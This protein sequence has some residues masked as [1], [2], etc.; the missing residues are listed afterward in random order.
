MA[1]ELTGDFDVVAEFAVPAA[2]R[3]LA[4][5][6]RSERFL[7]S[8]SIRVDDHARPGPTVDWPVVVGSLDTAGDPTVDHTRIA[9]SIP[10]SGPASGTTSLS[11]ALD[12][13]VNLDLVDANIGP[14][15]PSRLQGRAQ[16][17]LSPP[18]LEIPDGSGISVRVHQN[19]MSRYFPDPQ[20]PA[21]AEFIRGDLQ[22]TAPVNQVSSHTA[23]VVVIDIQANDVT[24]S[25]NPTW[26]DRPLSA[27]DRAGIQLMIRNALKTSF[28]PTNAT[29]PSNIRHMQFKTLLGP[30]SAVAVLLDMTAGPGNPASANRVVLR[31]GDDFAFAA[32]RDFIL[33]AFPRVRDNREHSLWIY[34]VTLDEPT[35]ELQDGRI[36]FTLEGHAHNSYL[37]DFDF[38]VRQA[39]TL[40]PAPTTP[41]GPLSTAELALLGDISVDIHGLPWGFGWIGDAFEPAARGA[42]RGQ[43]DAMLAN[44]QPTVRSQLDADKNLGAFL[45]S[46]L[47]PTGI[48]RPSEPPAYSLSYTS[49]EIKPSGIV[50]HG[51]L[52]VADWPPPRVEFEVIPVNPGPGHGGVGGGP[53]PP[54]G[55]DYSALKTW[56]PGGLIQR[57]E[58]SRFGTP[59][60]FSVD[61]HKFVYVDSPDLSPTEV[62]FRAA[63]MGFHPVCL[64]VRGLRISASGPAVAEPVSA[65]VCGYG[66]FPVFGDLSVEARGALPMVALTHPGAR[67]LVEVAGHASASLAGPGRPAPNL[68]VHF[69]DDKTAS[70]LA[71][72]AQAL[73][74]SKRVDAVT[75]ILAV[76][77]GEQM[78]RARHVDDVIYA[79]DQDG[80]WA[81]AF[82]VKATRRPLTL[83]VAPNGKVVWQ[84]E[85]DLAGEVLA[86]ALGKGLVARG[87]VTVRVLR[88]A[89]TIGQLSPDF[90]F[91]YAPG[92][93]LRLRQLRGRPVTL[94]FWRSVSKA[95]L[96]TVRDVQSTTRQA[97]A[98]GPI[99]LAI[100]DGEP[101]DL[102][103][104][105]A[106]Q[107][108]PSAV[109]VSDPERRIS[110]A[111]GVNIWPTVVTLDALGVVREL[112]Y[113]RMGEEHARREPAP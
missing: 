39:F 19:V 24:V 101:A 109:L 66:S 21:I 90:L 36:L 81:R 25:F 78:A 27:E 113:G 79:E 22:L 92:R 12:L 23:N 17:Q 60:P 33:S 107:I 75:A 88:P 40:V 28:V 37:P 45:K 91:E 64:T 93:R 111:Y 44:V 20:T 80:A 83:I 69:A 29:L 18:T 57:Y 74:D 108:G 63:V 99:V 46:L 50:M 49:A 7:H 51:S 103:Q 11:A 1:N 54:R 9:T 55:P 95:S 26:S 104:R 62:A 70:Q 106:A 86:A 30:P 2:N 105:L 112:R 77:S 41:G 61:D 38:T 73:R 31:A 8:I 13:P 85:G 47:T 53:L 72:L 100:N 76:L 35:F 89:V 5:M 87:A 10:L 67:G 42:L 59:Q 68:L 48:R 102:A 96:E 56:I 4:A 34:S 14:L 52:A 110:L 43:R 98:G 97:R 32:S 16:L 94:L 84:H 15:I 6:H 82:G 58:W 65:S 71:V 3:V